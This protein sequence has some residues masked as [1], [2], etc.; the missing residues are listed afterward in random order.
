MMS[1][2]AREG[3]AY[4]GET[5]PRPCHHCRG[6]CCFEIVLRYN[7][8]ALVS[9]VQGEHEAG[10]LTARRYFLRCEDCH[11]EEPARRA[12][13]NPWIVREPVP[14]FRQYGAVSVLVAITLFVTLLVLSIL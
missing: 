6:I 5:P 7:Y 4:L 12:E 9:S 3:S 10:Y 14:F 11:Q 1:W 13:V 2:V 8:S